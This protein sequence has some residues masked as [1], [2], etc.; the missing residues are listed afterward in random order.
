MGTRH[1]NYIAPGTQPCILVVFFL[2]LVTCLDIKIRL[3]EVTDLLPVL[4]NMY[5]VSGVSGHTAWYEDREDVCDK[6]RALLN[7]EHFL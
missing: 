6:S 2:I 7:N 1:N 3:L 4:F 5:T